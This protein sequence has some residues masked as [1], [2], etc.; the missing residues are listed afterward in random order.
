M[1]RPSSYWEYPI[2]HVI[3]FATIVAAFFA[4]RFLLEKLIAY[5]AATRKPN[6]NTVL[7][8]SRLRILGYAAFIWFTLAFL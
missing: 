1:L 6:G 8:D 7:T 2:L 5:R 3:Q 4:F